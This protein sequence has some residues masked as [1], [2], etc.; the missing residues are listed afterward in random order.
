MKAE[1]T[2]F[3]EDNCTTCKLNCTVNQKYDNF[4]NCDDGE[5]QNYKGVENEKQ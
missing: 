2:Y 3:H 4:C 1:I 5:C